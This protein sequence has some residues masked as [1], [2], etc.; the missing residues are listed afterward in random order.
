MCTYLSFYNAFLYSITILNILYRNTCNNVSFKRFESNKTQI[1]I[2]HKYTHTFE[3]NIWR[4]SPH[5]I[6][7]QNNIKTSQKFSS[8]YTWCIQPAALI[9]LYFLF[10]VFSFVKNFAVSILYIIHKKFCVF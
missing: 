1:L 3:R 7:N 4:R 5:R 10:L 6:S 8:T 2:K 9:Q